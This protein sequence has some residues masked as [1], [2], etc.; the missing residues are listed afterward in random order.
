MRLLHF[1]SDRFLS[2][3]YTTKTELLQSAKALKLK[4]KITIF[5]E[6]EIVDV[7]VKRYVS[8][9]IIRLVQVMITVLT[10]GTKKTNKLLLLL[11]TVFS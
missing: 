5:I 4:L 9:I 1:D 11:F 3:D 10:S 6:V 8:C 2:D 7:G